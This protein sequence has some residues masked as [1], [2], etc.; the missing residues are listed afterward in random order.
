MDALRSL[1]GRDRRAGTVIKSV[2][3]GNVCGVAATRSSGDLAANFDDSPSPGDCHQAIKMRS[4]DMREVGISPRKSEQNFGRL[5]N[6]S[7]SRISAGCFSVIA[8]ICAV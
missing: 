5:F 2:L 1:V 7:K 8:I 4:A 6:N 3:L